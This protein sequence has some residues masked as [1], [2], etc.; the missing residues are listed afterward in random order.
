[1]PTGLRDVAG[2]SRYGDPSREAGRIVLGVALDVILSDADPTPMP[3]ARRGKPRRSCG[4]VAST[5]HR[6]TDESSSPVG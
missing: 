3:M 6:R 4:H 5:Q 2:L 1:M